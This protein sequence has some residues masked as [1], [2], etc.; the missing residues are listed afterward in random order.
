[1]TLDDIDSKHRR[2]GLSVFGES[3]DGL[4]YTFV[5]WLCE[6]GRP[7]NIREDKRFQL[8]LRKLNSIYLLPSRKEIAKKEQD[9]LLYVLM[10]MKESILRSSKY[11]HA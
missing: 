9:M 5:L 4:T 10:H 8:F 11:F 3:N 1:M 6:S 2:R 7:S